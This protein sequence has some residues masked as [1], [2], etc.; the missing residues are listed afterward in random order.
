MSQISNILRNYADS[1]VYIDFR[2]KDKQTALQILDLQ[3]NRIVT[4]VLRVHDQ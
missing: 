3:G 1:D 4:Y 2:Q